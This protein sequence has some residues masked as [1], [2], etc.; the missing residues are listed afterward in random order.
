M[1]R[2]GVSDCAETFEGAF[3]QGDPEAGSK[4]LEMRN[5][6]AVKSLVEAV[7]RDDYESFAGVVSDSVTLKI[8]APPDVPFIRSAEGAAAFLDAVKKNF[9]MLEDQ[10]PVLLSIVAQ[11]ETVVCIVREQGR[12][13]E[14]GRRYDMHAMQEFL[15]RGGKLERI[16][17]ICARS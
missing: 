12:Y 16:F 5:V 3:A 2:K 4:S 6:A 11:G 9:A 17:E 8:L 14:D 15:F 13:A 1:V 10:N 7:A